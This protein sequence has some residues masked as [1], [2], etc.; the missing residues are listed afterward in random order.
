MAHDTPSQPHGGPPGVRMIPNQS[1]RSS[2]PKNQAHP[3]SLSPLA[4]WTVDPPSVSTATQRIASRFP[5]SA[6]HNGALHTPCTTYETYVRTYISIIY[7][8]IYV[9]YVRTYLMAPG[10]YIPTW[11]H[12]GS[13][14]GTCLY[15][16]LS[17]STKPLLCL[18]GHISKYR[19]LHNSRVVPAHIHVGLLPIPGSEARRAHKAAASGL[20]LGPLPACLHRCAYIGVRTRLR[21]PRSNIY[22]R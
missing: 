21:R 19:W 5:I 3:A 9:L 16:R 12:A 6:V 8:R 15:A 10:A 1:A 11:L 17:P 14:W 22:V 13:S 7:I 4:G 2:P 20:D 18:L